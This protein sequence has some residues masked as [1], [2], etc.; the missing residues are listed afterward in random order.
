MTEIE[1]NIAPE[2]SIDSE[3]GEHGLDTHSSAIHSDTNSEH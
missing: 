2:L 3:Q 1:Q